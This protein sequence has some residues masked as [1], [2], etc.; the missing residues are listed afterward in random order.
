M[1]NTTKTLRYAYRG[2]ALRQRPLIY[3]C[4]ALAQSAAASRVVPTAIVM[5]EW[6]DDGRGEFLIVSPADAIR[7]LRAG[8]EV[9]S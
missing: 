8:F 2:V 4:P 1:M 7:L 6:R 9:M 5:G 3:S